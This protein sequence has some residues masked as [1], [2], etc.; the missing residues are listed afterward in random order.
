[1]AKVVDITDKLDFEENP[2][3]V[4]KGQEIKVNNDALS[5]IKLMGIT[6]EEELGDVEKITKS[7]PLLF[8]EE[9]REKL[10]KL[11]LSFRDYTL[12]FQ[13]ALALATGQYE[14]D[15]EKKGEVVT[16]TTT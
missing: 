3:M 8:D 4:I 1:M 5:V 12:V 13:K 10:E 14:E 11:N 9:E 16:R 7:I 15:L 2:V 6:E